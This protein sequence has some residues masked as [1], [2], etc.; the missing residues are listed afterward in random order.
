MKILFILD[1]TTFRENIFDVA[2]E[3]S[4]YADAIWFRIKN[5]DTVD[6]L[7]LSTRL[8]NDL[9][10]S[11]LILSERPDIAQIA[12][13]NGVHLG[14]NSIPTH[15]IKKAFPDLELGYSAHS[16]NEIEEI[17]AD[18]YTLS[19]IFY[20]KKE[21]EV[22]PLG[23]VNVSFVGKRIYALGGI[24]INNVAELFN[25]GFYGIAGISFFKDLNVLSRKIKSC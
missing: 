21:Y 22:D 5:I 2:K 8:R 18:Y 3:A 11:H 15:T 6:I 9:P 13:F 10:S 25:R 4:T 24:S 14:S 20:T 19:P 16:I 23:P 17:E 1:Y 12:G 7:Y